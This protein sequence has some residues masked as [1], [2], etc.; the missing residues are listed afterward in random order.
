M[1]RKN[2]S[3]FGPHAYRFILLCGFLLPI[4]FFPVLGNYASGQAQEQPLTY[5][6]YPPGALNDL[7]PGY[8]LIEGDI[9]MRIGAIEEAHITGVFAT[10]FWTN[11]VIPF[12][13]DANVTQVNQTAMVAAMADWENAANLQFR[14]RTNEGNFVHIQNSTANNSAVGMQGGQQIINIFNWN[15]EFI[16]AHELGHCL[17]LWHEHNR[18]NRDSFITINTN[19]IQ[20]D[21]RNQFDKNSGA[22]EYWKYNYDFDSVMHYDQC[23]FSIDCPAGWTCNCTNT[24]ITVLAPNQAWQNLIGQRAH[25]STLDSLTMSFLYPETNWRF[26]DGSYIGSTEN[27]GF[28]TPY[29]HVSAGINGTPAGGTLWIQPNQYAETGT[30]TNALTIQAP[31]GGVTVGN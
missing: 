26:V 11:G 17:G 12:E 29:K 20:N 15:S 10:N 23:A 3:C 1:H 16:I 7:P 6:I 8:T 9:Q 13:F 19:N 2:Q 22:G 21:F 25:L 4:L 30:Y 18:P 31:L 28:L 5:P 14:Q 24:V 27:G